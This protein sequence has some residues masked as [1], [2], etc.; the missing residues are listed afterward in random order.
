MRKKRKLTPQE[1]EELN[2]LYELLRQEKEAKRQAE[3]R[4]RKIQ[5][6]IQFQKDKFLY[7]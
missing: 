3:I 2:E 5:R 6:Q 7:G 1:Q 4:S